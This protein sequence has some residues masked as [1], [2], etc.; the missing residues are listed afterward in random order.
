[1]FLAIVLDVFSIF[2][3]WWLCAGAGLLITPQLGRGGGGSLENSGVGRPVCGG[4]P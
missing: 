1:M 3:S 4:G 2:S